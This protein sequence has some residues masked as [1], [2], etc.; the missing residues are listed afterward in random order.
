MKLDVHFSG[1]KWGG[2]RGDR[3]VLSWWER[4]PARGRYWGYRKDWD[5]G[6]L[7]HFGWW[8]AEMTWRLPWT[9]H[10]GGIPTAGWVRNKS[11]MRRSR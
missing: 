10:D 5:N 6:P 4:L 9:H 8:F 1:I 2:S 3:I 11:W 7:S